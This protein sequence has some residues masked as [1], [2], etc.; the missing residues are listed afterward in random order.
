M[1]E[2][3]QCVLSWQPTKV[4]FGLPVRGEE[5]REEEAGKEERRER[6]VVCEGWREGQD[7]EDS[8]PPVHHDYKDVSNQIQIH[9]RQL[10]H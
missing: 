3:P 10:L 1:F 4:L 9:I 6:I 5:E 8:C 2:L 7:V